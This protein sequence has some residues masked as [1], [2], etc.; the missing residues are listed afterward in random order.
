MMVQIVYYI[1]ALNVARKYKHEFDLIEVNGIFSEG[2]LAVTLKKLYKI[3]IVYVHAGSYSSKRKKNF[4]MMKRGKLFTIISNKMM[5]I[6]EKITY[7][8]SDGIF[9]G[10]DVEEYY[11][12][13]KFKGLYSVLI[14][15]TDTEIFKS[16]DSIEFKNEL[17]LKNKKIISYIGRLS[18]EKNITTIIEAFNKIRETEKNIVLLIV[19]GGLEEKKL[20]LKVKE[21]KFMSDIYFYGMRKDILPFYNISDIVVIASKFEGICFSVIEAM[22]CE[23]I[24]VSSAVGLIPTVI[25]DNY[26]GFLVQGKKTSQ[27]IEINAT[28]LSNKLKIALYTTNI[29]GKNAKKTI[30]KKYSWDIII[31]KYIKL[32]KQ[33][34]TEYKKG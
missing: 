28:N 23:K 17:G 12:N 19:G 15:G 21:S 1:S 26:N 24:V 4:K 29:I 20:K 14:N 9:T 8:N 25:I 33:I 10:D 5:S 18:A 6:F 16:K 34:I 30:E 7:S 11:R 2:L 27:G 3:P 32:Y 31:L 13:L 22:A